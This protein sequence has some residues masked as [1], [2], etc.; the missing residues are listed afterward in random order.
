[1]DA[2]EIGLIKLSSFYMVR[3]IK[4]EKGREGCNENFLILSYLQHSETLWRSICLS[5]KEY[6]PLGS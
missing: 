5:D 3:L 1:M 2:S 4:A 6:L